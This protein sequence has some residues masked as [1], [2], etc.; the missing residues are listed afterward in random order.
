[1]IYGPKRK[2][3][4]RWDFTITDFDLNQ[5]HPVGFCM[6]HWQAGNKDGHHA[7]PRSAVLCFMDWMFS[8]G[9]EYGKYNITLL[10]CKVCGVKTLMTACIQDKPLFPL[11]TEHCNESSLRA[12]FQRNVGFEVIEEAHEHPTDPIIIPESA[13][14]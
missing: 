3:N 9:I 8:K 13:R 5:I 4:G 14:E 6:E 12:Y 11:C 2:K 10:P 1:M 7:D